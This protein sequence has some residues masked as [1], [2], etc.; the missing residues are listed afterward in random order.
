M[1]EKK[2]TKLMEDLTPILRDGEKVLGCTTG[3][4]VVERLGKKTLRRGTLFVSSQRVGVFTK[5]L[6]GHDLTDFAYGLLTS[7]QH[8]EGMLNGELNI[9]AAG[10]HLEVHQIPKGEASTLA[11][12]IR[13]HQAQ[14]TSPAPAQG[15]GSVADEI[16]K[17]AAL[18][19][20][21]ALTDEEFATHKATLLPQ[22]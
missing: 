16:A 10:T 6:G 20:S 5:K 1:N 18:R 14:S 15:S 21:G 12:L 17:L 3:T 4:A 22:S 9:L 13:T 8:K 2:T 19:D 7:V 11:D